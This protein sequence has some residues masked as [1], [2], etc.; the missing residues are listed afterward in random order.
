MPVMDHGTAFIVRLCSDKA[1]YEAVPKNRLKV[2][3]ARLRRS[4]ESSGDCEITL[5]TRQLM[6]VKKT[7]ATEIT[8]VADG[9]LIIRNVA[10]EEAARKIAEN[11]LPG[12][13]ASKR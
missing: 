9:R 5:W 12:L 11:L 13:L 8:I 1:A 10:D 4:L 6:V 7:D 3:L 2:D